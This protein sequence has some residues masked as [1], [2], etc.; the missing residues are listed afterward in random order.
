MC[1]QKKEERRSTQKG[2]SFFPHGITSDTHL[3]WAVK[4]G[5]PGLIPQH[6]MEASSGQRWSDGA[7]ESRDSNHG[8]LKC[9]V[10]CPSH[11]SLLV[12]AGQAQAQGISPCLE[13]TW[14]CCCWEGAHLCTAGLGCH[15]KREEGTMYSL[16]EKGGEGGL[17][18]A[19]DMSSTRK[20]GADI[21]NERSLVSCYRSC[22]WCPGDLYLT[23]WA[24][25]RVIGTFLP[26]VLSK[27]EQSDF[28]GVISGQ[29]MPLLTPQSLG[30]IFITDRLLWGKL[31][32]GR[33]NHCFR[34]ALDLQLQK[35]QH[36]KKLNAKWNMSVQGLTQKP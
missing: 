4:E 14:P 28:W 15:T 29:G 26:K 19:S 13:W 34:A 11:L 3:P 6:C 24:E 23:L 20:T 32:Q 1:K 36:H 16:I 10:W 27:H 31:R 2:Q 12:A 5:V 22:S 9:R 30:I 25:A 7:G 21:R 8:G 35:C 17:S 33:S 18:T